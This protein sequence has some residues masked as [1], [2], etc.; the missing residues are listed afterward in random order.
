[1]EAGIMRQVV[2]LLMLHPARLILVA[3]AVAVPAAILAAAQV[4]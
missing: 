3:V 1:M 2:A 4:R